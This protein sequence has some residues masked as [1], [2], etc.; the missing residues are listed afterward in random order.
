MPVS[1]ASAAQTLLVVDDDAGCLDEYVSTLQELGYQVRQAMSAPEALSVLHNDPSVGVIITDVN[2]PGMTGLDLMDKVQA[3]RRA[4]RV[5]EVVVITGHAS[6]ALA[7]S[8]L[9]LEAVD[10]LTKPVTRMDFVAALDRALARVAAQQEQRVPQALHDLGADV[11]NIAE[12]LQGLIPKAEPAAGEGPAPGRRV[13]ADYV[14]FF[15][16]LA[17]ARRSRVE[18]F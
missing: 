18:V 13:R 15:R 1:G 8:A 9:R 5:L 6:M 10:F 2:M 7:I 14:R 11:R 17:E 3:H 4:G 16:A 12:V